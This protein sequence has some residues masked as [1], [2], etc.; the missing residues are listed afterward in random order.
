MSTS[1]TAPRTVKLPSAPVLIGAVYAICVLG[2]VAFFTGEIA[3]TDHDPHADDGP[4]ESMI[5]ISIAGTAALVIGVA[6]LAW[7]GRTSDRARIGSF[8]LLALA[9]LTVPFF[10]SGAPGVLGA[11]AGACAGLTRGGRALSGAARIAGIVGLFIALLN[12]VLTVGGVVLDG[13]V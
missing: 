6:L 10:W 11:C 4:I 2:L 3:F 5:T 8:V 9:V 7:L 1:T 12:V 13:V